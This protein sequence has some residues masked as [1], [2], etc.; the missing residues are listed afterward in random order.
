VRRAREY[1]YS[2]TCC[3]KFATAE[4][5][6]AKKGT[7][8]GAQ[9]LGENRSKQSTQNLRRTP[10]AQL[11]PCALTTEGGAGSVRV[12]VLSR[13]TMAYKSVRLDRK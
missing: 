5:E 8:W 10:T 13:I 9:T 3:C 1:R 11:V 7:P 6:R 12:W 2:L 4:M